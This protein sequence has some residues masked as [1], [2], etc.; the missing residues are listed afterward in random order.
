MVYRIFRLIPLLLILGLLGAGGYYVKTRYVDP[1]PRGLLGVSPESDEGI[2][3]GGSGLAPASKDP[4]DGRVSPLALHVPELNRAAMEL[5]NF[6][7]EDPA[8]AR[9][10]RDALTRI[11]A[12][13]HLTDGQRAEIIASV[14]HARSLGCIFVVPFDAGKQ[15]LG[16]READLLVGGFKTEGVRRLTQDRTVVFAV[17]AYADTPGESPDNERSAT[18]RAKNVMATLRGRCGVQNT[19]YA[20]GMGGASPFSSRSPAGN[21]LAEI[22]AVYP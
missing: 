18:E 6:A 3:G 16:L 8:T 17:L 14:N 15:T 2:L 13:P 10:R 5:P 4:G 7:L 11:K 22:W 9:S 21:R 20:V 19:T 1:S 12:V